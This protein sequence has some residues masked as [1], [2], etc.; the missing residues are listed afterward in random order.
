MKLLFVI[1]I[2]IGCTPVAPPQGGWRGEI[3]PFPL[4]FAPALAH[5][6]VEE[7][8]FSPGFF[9]PGTAGYWTYAFV[10][11]LDDAAEL[12]G[13]AL[14]AELTAYFRGLVAAVDDKHR[15]AS[16]DPIAAR[17][18]PDRDGFALSIHAFDA[19]GTAAPIDLVGRAARTPCGAGALWVFSLAPA[20]AAV[21]AELAA[22]ARCKQRA[23]K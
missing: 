10:W 9:H 15:I 13:R 2:A 18:V 7:L 8:R 3:I 14:A 19:F 4:D 20:G 22:Q 16:L 6:G 21:P 1:T 17:A 5:R 11:R 12:D 23:T